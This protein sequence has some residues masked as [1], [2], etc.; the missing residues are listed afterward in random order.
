MLSPETAGKVTR[1]EGE[2][3]KEEGAGLDALIKDLARSLGTT[4]VVVTHDE[5]L[6]GRCQQRLRLLQG[7]LVAA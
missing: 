1:D 4:F 6:A 7:R 5:A 3:A 2:R